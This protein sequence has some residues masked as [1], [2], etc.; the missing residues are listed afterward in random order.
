VIASTEFS[1]RARFAARSYTPGAHASRVRGSGLDVAAVVPIERAR[2]MRR[3][4]LHAALRDPHERW[5]VREH[6]QR[7][8]IAVRLLVDV[9]ASV[10]AGLSDRRAL[11]ISFAQALRDSVAR[12]GDAFALDAFAAEPLQATVASRAR[13]PAAAAVSQLAA[14]PFDQPGATGVLPVA[15]ALPR[16]P[17]LVFLVSDFHW[18]V[19]LLDEALARLARHDVVPVWMAEPLLAERLP[20]FGLLA[21]RDAESGAERTV[22]MRPALRRRWIE[23]QAQHEAQLRACFA[24]HQRVP[25]EMR[26]AFDADA[27]S[28][29]FAARG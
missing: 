22:W 2:D 26:G 6:H 3:L 16:E 10:A 4:D 18:P 20:T 19:A 25:L 24:R 13:G 27:V 21:L 7:S 23:A 17:S 29:Y 9:S 12:S 11:S 5:W 1:Y 8:S 28:N 14:L 15:D